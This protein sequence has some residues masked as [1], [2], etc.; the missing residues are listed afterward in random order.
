[1]IGILSEK[2]S[3]STSPREV[4][5]VAVGFALRPGRLGGGLRGVKGAGERD[6]GE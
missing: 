1:V 4:L 6:R 2:S 5:R 3:I